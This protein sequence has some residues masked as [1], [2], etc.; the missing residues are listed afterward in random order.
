MSILKDSI[1]IN[2]K[3]SDDSYCKLKV[4]PNG[5]VPVLLEIKIPHGQGRKYITNYETFYVPE[6]YNYLDTQRVVNEWYDDKYPLSLFKTKREKR[7]RLNLSLIE[8]YWINP[9]EE[10]ENFNELSFRR[11][12]NKE[13]TKIC[14]E[15]RKEKNIEWNFHLNEPLHIFTYEEC[16]VKFLE[17]GGSFKREKVKESV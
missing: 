7:N 11:Y 10:E 8:W 17:N 12:M 4:C 14:R 5:Y 3:T 6:Y 15:Y 9:I 2:E 13:H 16:R 1:I